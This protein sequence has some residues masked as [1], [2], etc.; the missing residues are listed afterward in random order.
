MSDAVWKQASLPVSRGGLDIRRTED[1]SLPAFLASVHSVHHLILEIASAADLD[2][3][4]AD[5]AIQ[6]SAATTHQPPDQPRIQKLW[7]RPIVEQA[8]QD[9]F[10]AVGE[11]GRARLL[12][13]TSEFAGAWL[14]TLP[15][16]SLGNLLDDNQLRITVALRLGATVCQPH[17]CQ[18]C[19][20]EVREDG[21]HGLSCAY[22]DSRGSRHAAIN[23]VVQRALVSAGIP[24]IL[25]PPGLCRADGKRPDG[26]TMTPFR[27]G[28][29]LLW[30]ATVWDTVAP[31]HIGGYMTEAGRAARAVEEKKHR[32]YAELEGRYLFVPLAFETFGTWGAEAKRLISEICRRITNRTRGPLNF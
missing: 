13:V 3:I 24:A 32:T 23:D 11:V 9:V 26:M 8:V 22:G 30:D 29:A 28:K 12:A 19:G 4:T 17:H 20:K 27:Q 6:W 21:H 16:S 25:E 2:A 10:A 15:V 7:D 5:A 18:A 1:L 14:N 31:S